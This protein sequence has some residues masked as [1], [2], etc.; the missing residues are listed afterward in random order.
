ML[1]EKMMNPVFSH[2]SP[3]ITPELVFVTHCSVRALW[4]CVGSISARSQLPAHPHC[5][6]RQSLDLHAIVTT[7][8]AVVI[9]ASVAASVATS[10]STGIIASVASVATVAIAR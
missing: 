7:A 1:S 5:G 9:S 4:M 10:V 2:G 3:C 8:T 6:T